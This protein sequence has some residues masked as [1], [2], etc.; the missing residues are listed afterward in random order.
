MT[1]NVSTH[2][3]KHIKHLDQNNFIYKV[4]KAFYLLT[5]Q[6]ERLYEVGFNEGFL[7]AANLLQKQTIQDSNV[8]KI[9]GYKTSKPKPSQVQSIINRV[10]IHFEVHK[11][12][13]MNKSRTTDIV[14]A[15]NVI[16]N[17][18]YEKY[19]MNLTDIGR[20]FGQDHT[21]VLHSIEMKRD[22]KRFWS[23]EQSLWQDFEKLIF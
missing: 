2:Y 5:N 15:R 16:H 19:Y 6:E 18:L 10:C 3:N 14:R 22:Q 1:I 23:P 9:I 4:K 21:T 17:L 13:L 8:K 7:F 11:E 20:Y 12:T